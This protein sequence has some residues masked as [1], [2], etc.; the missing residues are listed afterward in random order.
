[1]AFKVKDEVKSVKGELELKDEKYT[2]TAY[3]ITSDVMKMIIKAQKEEDELSSI[4]ALDKYFDE[5]IEFDKKGFKNPKA[6]VRKALDRVGK[7][8]EF[9]NYVIEEVGKQTQK[10]SKD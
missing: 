7:L 5:C 2:Y 10:E 3:P 1:M 4:E 8:Y 9:I 6:E